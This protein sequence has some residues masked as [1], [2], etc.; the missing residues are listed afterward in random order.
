M[1]FSNLEFY[2][3]LEAISLKE[4]FKLL[5]SFESISLPKSTKYDLY[6][7]TTSKIITIIP[8]IININS[9]E[10]CPLLSLTIRFRKLKSALIIHS[11]TILIWRNPL[12]NYQSDTILIQ[13]NLHQNYQSDTILI[14]RNLHQNYQSDTILIQRNLLQNY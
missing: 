6:I 1:F 2:S 14:Q 11:P 8:P 12:Q 7:E 10:P 3:N 4:L 13:R 5:S 9:T